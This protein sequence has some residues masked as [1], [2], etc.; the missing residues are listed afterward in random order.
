[1]LLS[2]C[3]LE[4]ERERDKLLTSGGK[5]RVYWLCSR[6]IPPSNGRDVPSVM[7]DSIE[8]Q[9]MLEKFKPSPTVV[10]GAQ[11]SSEHYLTDLTVEPVRQEM[12]E[13]KAARNV[14]VAYAVIRSNTSATHCVNSS[15]LQKEVRQACQDQLSYA[16]AADLGPK[17]GAVFNKLVNQTTSE[18]VVES[19]SV[20]DAVVV[21]VAEQNQTLLTDDTRR[22]QYRRT[23]FCLVVIILVVLAIIIVPIVQSILST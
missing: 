10:S 22:K 12:D 7:A 11:T 13:E 2:V 19:L 6:W 4:S 16:D 9:S 15:E 8:L 3:R 5:N 1:M 14:F 20:A 18:T 23:I 21:A 17:I